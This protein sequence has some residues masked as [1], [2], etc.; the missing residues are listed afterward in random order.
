MEDFHFEHIVCVS[1]CESG[2]DFR[3]RLVWQKAILKQ[4]S[5]RKF[6]NLL[7]KSKKISF[8]VAPSEL[9]VA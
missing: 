6:L 8:L 5:K 9:E 2:E 4:I 1:V 7:K 3:Y